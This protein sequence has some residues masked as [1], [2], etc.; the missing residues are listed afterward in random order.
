MAGSKFTHSSGQNG[1]H[2]SVSNFSHAGEDGLFRVHPSVFQA[3]AEYRPVAALESTI[4]T[5]G[6]P[7]PHSVSGYSVLGSTERPAISCARP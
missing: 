5:Q 1:C 6:I 3:L 7:Y 4:F 2:S